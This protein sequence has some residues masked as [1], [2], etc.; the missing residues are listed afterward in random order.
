MRGEMTWLKK[1]EGYL[2]TCSEQGLVIAAHPECTPLS[3]SRQDTRLC[4]E[5][6]CQATP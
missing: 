3:K 6:L 2:F 1:S 5:H 4:R